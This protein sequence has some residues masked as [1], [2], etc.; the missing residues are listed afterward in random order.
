MT[1]Q[2]CRYLYLV[3]VVLAALMTASP[4]AGAQT[5]RSPVRPQTVPELAVDVELQEV[6]VALGDLLARLA[7]RCGVPLAA[8]GAEIAEQKIILYAPRQPLGTLLDQVAELLGA[9]WVVV[10]SESGKKKREYC[11]VRARQALEDAERYRREQQRRDQALWR[12][13]LKRYQAMI[14]VALESVRRPA[15]TTPDAVV[16]VPFSIREKELVPLLAHLTPQQIALLFQPATAT[17]KISVSDGPRRVW[18]NSYVVK[19]PAFA[20]PLSRFPAEARE[21][22]RAILQRYAAENPPPPGATEE[23]SYAL[24]LRE[25]DLVLHFANFYGDSVCLYTTSAR[26]PGSSPEFVIVDSLDGFR[27]D[28]SHPINQGL[29]SEEREA[30]RQFREARYGPRR[31]PLPNRPGRL[32]GLDAEDARK[33]LEVDLRKMVPATAEA[34]ELTLPLALL[35]MHQATGQT[36]L[37]D[38]FTKPQRLDLSE[39][40]LST[41]GEFLEAVC[42]AFGRDG[43]VD[44]RGFRF[45]SVTWPDDERSEVPARTLGHWLEARARLGYLPADAWLA[46]GRLSIP[47]LCSLVSPSDLFGDTLLEPARRAFSDYDVIQFYHQL[48]PAQQAAARR[49]PLRWQD[50]TPTQRDA[51]GRLAVVHHGLHVTPERLATSIRLSIRSD[52]KESEIPPGRMRVT[53]SLST[54]VTEYVGIS[55]RL[56]FPGEEERIR[57]AAS[58]EATTR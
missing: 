49:T 53:F 21:G 19:T 11:L 10:E 51:V 55:A 31:S 46:M 6:G 20:V 1:A 13:R 15:E 44:A 16:R 17:P 23:A 35:A 36:V 3:G 2:D 18:G 8:E 33:P 58:R 5:R 37:A 12:G 29:T 48:T 4:P 32:V 54:L 14:R 22:V 43:W 9:R 57:R 41:R 42:R 52:T 30:V 34:A 40:P 39:K 45:R 26:R 47:Q 38:Y 24:H 27:A 28:L 7:S 56:P 25:P 50:L